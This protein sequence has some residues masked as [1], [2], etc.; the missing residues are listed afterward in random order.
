MEFAEKRFH[1]WIIVFI[2]ESVRR[3]PS[4]S[5]RKPLSSFA[6]MPARAA[7]SGNG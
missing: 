3:E 5:D 2:G 7:Q 4:K 6:L 1:K